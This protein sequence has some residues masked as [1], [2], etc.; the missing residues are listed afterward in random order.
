MTRILQSNSDDVTV[1]ISGP[2]LDQTDFRWICH[3]SIDGLN[4]RLSSYSV[5]VDS[6]DALLGSIW[7]VGEYLKLHQ[8]ERNLMWLG[9]TNI[10]M[11]VP[12]DFTWRD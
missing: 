10:W 1:S 11:N 6:L 8:E 5:G 9:S 7:M 12:T 2:S 4:E 3:W